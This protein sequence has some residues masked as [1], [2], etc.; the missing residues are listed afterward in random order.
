MAL[1]NLRFT[2]KGV[3]GL[4]ALEVHQ[5]HGQQEDKAQKLVCQVALGQHLGEGAADVASL[6]GREGEG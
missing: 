1:V 3:V 5:Q 4:A 2:G 6:E